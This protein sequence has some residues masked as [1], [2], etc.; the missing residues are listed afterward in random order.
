MI[1][2]GIAVLYRYEAFLS[3]SPTL[4]ELLVRDVVRAA[5]SVSSEGTS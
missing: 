4:E 2:A 5:L 3:L 1:E